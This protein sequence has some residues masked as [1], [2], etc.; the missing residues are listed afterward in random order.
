MGA[1]VDLLAA[2]QET[3]IQHIAWELFDPSSVRRRSF[4]GPGR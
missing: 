4:P 2:E 3:V 1:V